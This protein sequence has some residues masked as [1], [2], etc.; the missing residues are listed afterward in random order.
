MMGSAWAG[1]ATA[2]APGAWW[3]N[4]S[5]F[6]AAAGTA[7]RGLDG[8]SRP[9]GQGRTNPKGRAKEGAGD[10]RRAG[11]GRRH[12]DQGAGAGLAQ[13]RRWWSPPDRQLAADVR[14][15]GAEV[16]RSGEP[17]W[18]RSRT[19][20]PART[21]KR[22]RRE[23]RDARRRL[24]YRPGLR[25]D[26]RIRGAGAGAASCCS[27]SRSQ[28]SAGSELNALR[29]IDAAGSAPTGSSARGAAPRAPDR[30]HHGGAGAG[31]GARRGGLPRRRPGAGLR[32]PRQPRPG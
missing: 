4:C 7:S 6:G 26:L 31:G 21:R 14:R 15:L 8:A 13:Q 29:A 19:G 5:A 24:I 10:V 30:L 12:P 2:P 16:M 27:P 23:E 18:M 28:V 17:G 25:V 1:T 32:Q 11:D 9:R 20:T 3:T 22:R